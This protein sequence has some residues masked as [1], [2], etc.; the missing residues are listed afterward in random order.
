MASSGDLERALFYLMVSGG[1]FASFTAGA[2]PFGRL[3]LRL[4]PATD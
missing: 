1:V 3:T 4:E 2:V